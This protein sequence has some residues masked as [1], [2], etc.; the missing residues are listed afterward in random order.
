MTMA[1]RAHDRG[2]FA[3]T[4]PAGAGGEAAERRAGRV[5]CK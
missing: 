1:L 5:P 4:R 2:E 3:E